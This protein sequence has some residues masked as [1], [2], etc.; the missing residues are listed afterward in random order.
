MRST[1][2]RRLT[3]VLVL[4]VIV[5]ACGDDDDQS[6]SATTN[7]A[8]TAAPATTGA[9][10]ATSGRGGATTAPA[11]AA[12]TTARP[13]ALDYDPDGVV[14]IG[15]AL[16][17]NTN[18]A[19]DPIKS[20][21]NFDTMRLVYDTFLR[22][23]ADG[24][25]E[26]GLARSW[27]VVDGS[28][29]KLELQPGVTFSDGTPF[30]GEAVKAGLLRNATQQANGFRAEVKALQDVVVDDPTHVT[31]KFSS[32]VA[33]SWL[34]LLASGEG[35]IVSPKAV[36]DGVDLNSKPVGA[37]PFVLESSTPDDS[38]VLKKNP[39]YFEAAKIKLAGI[40]FVHVAD[41]TASSTAIRSDAVDLLP[42]LQS[43]A[44]AT[45]LQ[46]VD[47]LTVA[48]ATSGNA[49]HTIFLCKSRP[50]FDNVDVRKALNFAVDRN[51]LVPRPVRQAVAPRGGQLAP[52]PPVPRPRAGRL[53]HLRPQPGAPTAGPGRLRRG[54]PAELHVVLHTGQRP[55]RHGDR[56]GPV[57]RGRH[58]DAA[59]AHP[60]PL[61]RLPH[62]RP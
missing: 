14:R 53:V 15:I 2:L 6:G 5:A 19:W 28:T 17:A 38:A 60:G 57:R 48:S 39:S 33:G 40:E 62:Q 3:A 1:P 18:A 25:Y 16:A 31:L 32:P 61:H 42:Q 29:L 50:P 30:N 8:V 37:G 20:F 21:S 24:S 54:Q 13:A 35:M 45:E 23:K 26:P 47:N 27:Q 52:R 36:A 51:A 22:N 9:P 58:R 10:T 43:S 46:S 41:P 49:W 12:P 11:T 56:A 59:G 4:T 7:V 44:L 55:A 34:S